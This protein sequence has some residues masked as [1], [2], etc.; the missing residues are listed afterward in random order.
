VTTRKIIL[1]LFVLLIAFGIINFGVNAF[2]TRSQLAMVNSKDSATQEQGVKRL[3]ERKVL[4][5]ALQ[6]GAPPETRQAAI[7]TLQRMAE[8][9]KNLDAFNELLQ[10]LKDPDTESAEKKT[11]PVRDAAK[12]AVAAVGTGYPD[13]L[14]DAAKDPDKNIQ[15]QSRNALKKI[16]A[17][18]KEKMAERLDDGGLRA[19]LGDILASI[20]PETI[21]LITPYLSQEKL[22]KFKDKPDD[23]VKAKLQLIEIMGKF[24]QPEAATAVI[25][26]KDDEDPNVRRGVVTA[27]ANIGD[28]VGASVLIQALTDPA[29]DASARAAAAGAL[30]G[31]ASPEA[32]A[33]MMKALSDYDSD[34]ATAAAAGLR[35]AGDKAA[36]SVAQ[37]LKD[38][39]P[40]VR[41][42]AAEAAGGMRTIGLAV[43]ALSD[44]DATVRA[45]A[46]ESLGDVLARANGIRADLAKLATATDV[47]EQ[48]KA[49][50]SLQTRGAILELL[51]PGAPP[52]AV[53]N[54]VKMLND[55]AA[56]ESDE[57]KRKPFE[58]AVKKLTD[59][60]VIAAEKTAAPLA[61]GTNPAS[62]QPL[63]KALGDADGTVAANA[64][65]AL[66]R[67]GTAVVGPLVALLGQ[68]DDRI[69]YYASQSL[70]LINRAAVDALIAQ[71]AA[72]KPGARW[73]AITLGEIGDQRAVAPLETLSKSADPDT[74][75]AAGAALAKVRAI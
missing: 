9:G 70:V 19:P 63:L 12:D 60:A 71:A 53:A 30:G 36:S 34:V 3:M 37:A 17:P 8:G 74:A 55:K 32:N 11:H 13:R 39:N 7:A 54:V 69:A 20:G 59:P 6:G 4:F 64:A 18:L 65:A 14:L 68:A 28:P 58:D 73:A 33:A 15:E 40:A 50:A 41:A 42:R 66:G 47:K 45:R 31:I 49:Y 24:K 25:P 75:Y 61:D 62:F 51:R 67:L 56:A 21:P 57:K 22:D 52:A 48:E 38:P 1:G 29:T 44:P 5:D 72:G 23:L 16:G 43:Q 35:R 2:Q 27:L 10:M 26:F 46:A